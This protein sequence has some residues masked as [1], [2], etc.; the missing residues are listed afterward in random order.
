[1]LVI[2]I[3]IDHSVETDKDKTLDPTK[4]DKHKADAYNVDMTVGE[5]AVDIKIVVIEMTVK[6][7]VKV[8]I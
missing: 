2:E 1:M 6:V 3:E 5:E 4:G 8:L 7:K